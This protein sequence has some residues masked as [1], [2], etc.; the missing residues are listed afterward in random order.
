MNKEVILF[1]FDYDEFVKGNY[2]LAEYDNYYF[3][4]RVYD[5]DQ[6]L[7]TVQSGEDC[8][9]P[10]NQYDSLMNFFWD[11]NQHDIDIA[12]EIKKRIGLCK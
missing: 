11:N 4:K 10:Q 1:I 12:E 3:G 9:V 7:A 8:H 5:F 6:L 2:E